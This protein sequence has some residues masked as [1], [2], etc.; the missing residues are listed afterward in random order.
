MAAACKPCHMEST[1][2]GFTPV[3]EQCVL[4]RYTTEAR[5]AVTSD[6]QVLV[7]YL[8]H[9]IQVDT[10]YGGTTG[11]PLTI[12]LN[13]RIAT[14]RTTTLTLTSLDSEMATGELCATFEQGV[15]EGDFVALVE[16]GE[17]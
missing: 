16:R 12:I 2:V 4:R 1:V 11:N 13:E 5:L 7:A 8:P 9:D 17:D 10:R 6:S 14:I 15:V 3:C